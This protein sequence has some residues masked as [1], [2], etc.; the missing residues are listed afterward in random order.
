MPTCYHKRNSSIK[1]GTKPKTPV[2]FSSSFSYIC[3]KINI[4]IFSF[5]AE[6]SASL[7]SVDYYVFAVLIYNDKSSNYSIKF[8]A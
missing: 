1:F 6:R 4:L 7:F 2:S 3:F 5:T 8:Y